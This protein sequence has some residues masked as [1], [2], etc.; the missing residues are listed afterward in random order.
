MRISQR[1]N[2]LDKCFTVVAPLRP[3]VRQ[4]KGMTANQFRYQHRY[5]GGKKAQLL[6]KDISISVFY[7]IRSL[8]RIFSFVRYPL[9]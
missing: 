1:K 8:R 2:R 4:V 3:A 6:T 9:L 7:F 5:L